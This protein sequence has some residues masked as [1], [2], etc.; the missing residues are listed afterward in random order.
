MKD[1]P[2]NYDIVKKKIIESNI[3]IIGKASIRMI[4]KLVDEIQQETGEKYIR[5]EM[6]VPGLKP[7]SIG[8][9]AEIRALRNGVAAKYPDIYGTP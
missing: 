9:E 1:T 8:V 5:M 7:S 6:G 3:P 4:K 2:I